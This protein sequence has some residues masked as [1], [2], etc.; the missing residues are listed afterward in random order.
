M[1]ELVD[2]LDE[3]INNVLE[4]QKAVHLS[5]APYR[6]RGRITP[7][8]VRAWYYIPALDLVAASRFIGCKGMNR[9]RYEQSTEIDVKVTEPHLQR[10]GWF[11]PL[12]ENEPQY[13][14]ARSTAKRLSPTCKLYP[15]ARF[16]VLKN[17]YDR[18]VKEA[19]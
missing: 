1:L 8:S 4:Y 6:R 19:Q 12:E 13:E 17:T 14:H 5:Y 15:S 11:R 9:E 18:Q 7:S 16:Y 3:L 2:T 10:K